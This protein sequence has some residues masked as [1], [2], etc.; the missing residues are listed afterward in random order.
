MLGVFGYKLICLNGVKENKQSWEKL[1]CVLVKNDLNCTFH[2]LLT[3]YLIYDD[4]V[5]ITQ[6]HVHTR[7]LVIK[8]RI[9]LSKS[10]CIL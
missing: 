10:L 1:I 2:S 8:H 6:Q 7:G 3:M 5:Q 9:E 4:E